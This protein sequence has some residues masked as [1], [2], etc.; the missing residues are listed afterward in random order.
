MFIVLTHFHLLIHDKECEGYLTVT[1]AFN[2]NNTDI[3][4]GTFI[5]K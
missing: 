1:I 3:N 5:K 2:K 4:L